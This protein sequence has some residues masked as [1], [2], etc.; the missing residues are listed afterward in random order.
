[1]SEQHVVEAL[2]ELRGKGSR[3]V[4]LIIGSSPGE[5]E[6]AM[7][8]NVHESTWG[9]AGVPRQMPSPEK[10][11]TCERN[12]VRRCEWLSALGA[13]FARPVDEKESALDLVWHSFP[14][15]ADLVL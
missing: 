2:A 1:M 5:Q 13:P 3:A 12:W 15:Y 9:T 8:K 7:L 11:K 6:R 4:P 14:M 10:A